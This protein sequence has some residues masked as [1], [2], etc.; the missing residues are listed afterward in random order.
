MKNVVLINSPTRRLCIGSVSVVA[1]D[2]L[3]L[4]IY[5]LIYRSN[6]ANPNAVTSRVR[7]Y[8]AKS[9]SNC[10]IVIVV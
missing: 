4:N 3:H 7:V 10:C 5:L 8:A 6:I 1:V 9:K 2:S